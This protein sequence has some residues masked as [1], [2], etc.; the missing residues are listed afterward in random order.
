MLRDHKP[1]GG[2]AFPNKRL[3]RMKKEE[4]TWSCHHHPLLLTWLKS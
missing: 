1:I 3:T 2:S 4:R